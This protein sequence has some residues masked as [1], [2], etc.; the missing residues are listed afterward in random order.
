MGSKIEQ[1]GL[2]LI[3]TP[4]RLPFLG[5]N[6]LPYPFL[7][8]AKDMLFTYFMGENREDHSWTEPGNST[9]RRLILAPSLS[10]T[11]LSLTHWNGSALGKGER[12]YFKWP[13]EYLAN[14]P[15]T[16]LQ[17]STA[18]AAPFLSFSEDSEVQ[19]RRTIAERITTNFSIRNVFA[20]WT[21]LLCLHLPAWQLPEFPCVQ[22]EL[23]T[24][25][26][27]ACL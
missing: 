5:E 2:Q 3:N 16:T 15:N 19:L 11:R 17:Q 22:S 23:L 24:V 18:W 1:K 4:L 13:L 14:T 21:F 20:E 6:F 9:R 25:A 12:F 8:V 7:N 10:Q 27:L 26:P